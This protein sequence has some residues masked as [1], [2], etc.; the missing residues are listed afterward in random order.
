MQSRNQ[1]WNIHFKPFKTH[2]LNLS[3]TYLVIVFLL[4]R[5]KSTLQNSAKD[6]CYEITKVLKTFSIIYQE[7]HEKITGFR[8]DVFY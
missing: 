2:P 4:H 6:H 5:R 1:V 8:R 7:K 3:Q